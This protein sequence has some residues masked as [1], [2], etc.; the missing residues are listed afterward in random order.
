MADKTQLKRQDKIELSKVDHGKAM[1]QALIDGMIQNPDGILRAKGGGRFSV[2]RDL[3]R[4]DQVK[5][6]FQQ[7]RSAV[8]SAEYFVQPA[9]ESSQDSMLAEF[10]EWQLK[11]I[12][13]DK[14]CD[15]MLYAVHYGYS[16]A[17]LLYG[18]DQHTGY[19]GLTDI[20]VRDRERFKFDAAHNVVLYENAQKTTLPQ[21]KFWT[22][23]YGADHS[24]NPYGE[25]L[26]HSLYWPVFFKRSG[27][28]FWMIYLEKFGMPTALA[29]LSQS[30]IKDPDQ[31][32]MALEMLDAIHSDS[33]VLV[34]SD[35]EAEFLEAS[36]SG[37]VTYEQL[38]DKM[39]AAISKIVLS[40]TMT[41]DNGSSR[42][43]AEVHKGVKDEVIK[44]DADLLCQTFNEQVIKRL[45]DLNFGE[46]E[47]YPEVWR[48]TE[49]E[50]DLN[51]LADRDKKIYEMGYGPT[52][53][54][55]TDTYGEGWEK[56]EI[57]QPATQGGDFGGEQST[58]YAEN[59]KVAQKGA[60][61]RKDQG[62]IKA[63][64]EAMALAYNDLIGP[65]VRQI[66][67]FAEE[68]GDLETMRDRLEE[69]V[70][71]PNDETVTQ[72]E[73]AT[74]AARMM[75]FFKGSK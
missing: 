30:Q 38:C 56:R 13:F 23:N 33:G 29:K 74:F 36:R 11:R 72:I 28:K 5:S 4:D 71:D 27:V 9:G 44:A 55:I 16:V 39:D 52:Q 21:E 50:E 26:A 2:Y 62:D 46:Q 1:G 63:G 64:A 35:F 59:G 32:I 67:A 66:L 65:R 34:P 70:T 31:R 51:Q 54:Y 58:D 8:T 57:T 75:G 20:K 24:D 14:I 10:V 60:Q 7:R 40:Q 25:G 69:L 53:D 6:T 41:T 49:P 42:S 73:N 37:S 19:I 12:K 61:Q 3:L 17:E 43:Q 45:I 15:M 18:Y 68:S 22:I 47:N 48:R